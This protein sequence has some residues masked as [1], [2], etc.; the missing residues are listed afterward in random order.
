M[1]ITLDDPTPA[2]IE[3]VARTLANL[4]P[5]EPWP[6]NEDLG[7]SPTGTRDD[8]FRDLQTELAKD[9]IIAFLHTRRGHQK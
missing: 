9:A 6:T 3:A 8:E 2:E 7:G 4:E 5:G 1:T